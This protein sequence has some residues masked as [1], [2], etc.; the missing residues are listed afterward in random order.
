MSATLIG[1]LEKIQKALKKG[2]DV[3]YNRYKKLV[4]VHS[5]YMY[6]LMAIIQ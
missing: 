3:N 2:A 6:L 1:D 5:E 4:S